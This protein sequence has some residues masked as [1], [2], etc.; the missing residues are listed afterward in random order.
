M[1]KVT[2]LFVS[3]DN[4]VR[5][6][7]LKTATNLLSRPIQKLHKLEVLNPETNILYS[8]LSDP[9]IIFNDLKDNSELEFKFNEII[10]NNK[11]LNLDNN[12]SDIR[13]DPQGEVHMASNDQEYFTEMKYPTEQRDGQVKIDITRSGRVSKPPDRLIYER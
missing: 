12:K 8:E 11:S 10:K 2:K 13:T 4:K 9:N 7:E 3:K 6:V 1:G 5:A